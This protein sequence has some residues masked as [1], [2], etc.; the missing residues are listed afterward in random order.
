MRI[1]I[2][3]NLQLFLVSFVAVAQNEMFNDIKK[4]F[5]E[6]NGHIHFET[7]GQ[8]METFYITRDEYYDESN[9]KII[10]D[11]SSEMQFN[12]NEIKTF[13]IYD[14]QQI[15]EQK[16]IKKLKNKAFYYFEDSELQ[17]MKIINNHYFVIHRYY[18][19]DENEEKNLRKQK[20][21]NIDFQYTKFRNQKM[22]Y[23]GSSIIAYSSL[24]LNKST[25]IL[26]NDDFYL[27]PLKKDIVIN[28]ENRDWLPFTSEKF[29]TPKRLLTYRGNIKQLYRIEKDNQQLKISD[30]RSG[31]IYLLDLEVIIFAN[32]YIFIKKN[33]SFTTHDI[34]LSPYKSS[35][36]LRAVF[37]DYESSYGIQVLIENKIKWLLNNGK[38]SEKQRKKIYFQ[39]GFC[40]Y[41][42]YLENFDSIITKNK[43]E[44]YLKHKYLVAQLPDYQ[45]FNFLNNEKHIDFTESLDSLIT[46]N[47]IAKD[48]NGLH[49]FK[50]NVEKEQIKLSLIIEN[51][52][53]F[54]RENN[55]PN[56][57][58]KKN[59]LWGY[60]PLMNKAKFQKLEDF[61]FF[62]SR[63]IMPNGEAG[64]I[65]KDGN[66][67]L[68]S[69][70]N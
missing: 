27:L 63:F 34:F 35:P 25:T 50:V 47:L 49:L 16:L 26:A 8:N 30:A 48:K 24:T 10:R 70:K 21:E 68:D 57:K 13:S 2:L 14:F 37:S 11:T 66:I 41:H 1:I 67:Y 9:L 20:F 45:D 29:S 52:D 44:M 33:G 17:V 39:S 23:L 60:Y 18:L 36:K 19:F 56:F 53:F 62:F 40:G 22:K 61:N 42:N 5:F 51:M 6:K 46:N 3:L 59:N 65:T 28:Y 7:V 55:Y 4:V 12:E 15:T 32:N 69:Y 58:F 43:N 38:F 54:S 64:W 31:K